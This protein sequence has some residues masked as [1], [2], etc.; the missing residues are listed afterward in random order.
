MFIDTQYVM[1]QYVLQED[2]EFAKFF[3]AV[4]NKFSL[5]AIK[6]KIDLDSF[7]KIFLNKQPKVNLKINEI[8]KR[9]RQYNINNQ[10]LEKIIN[11]H[12]KLNINIVRSNPKKFYFN[13]AISNC[14]ND[15]K[16]ELSISEQVFG[17]LI[18]FLAVL[19]INSFL[20]SF[21]VILFGGTEAAVQTA[22]F[23]TT[24][25]VAPIVEESGKLISVE[26][27][28]TGTYFI[29]FNIGE[30][31]LYIFNLLGKYSLPQIIMGRILATIM[32]AICTQIHIESHQ[33][34]T[35]GVGWGIAVL[36][37]ML[38]NLIASMSGG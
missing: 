20:L 24:V 6:E 10:K 11:K 29:V 37:H 8:K 3:A 14:V 21:F 32:H 34:K 23:I 19:V 33:N 1:D 28:M 15:I 25:F 38:W 13:T 2:I 5:D 9:L 30:W 27:K 26:E 36:I 12:V 7:K 16:Q 4:K 22:M 17:S 31:L 18:L 35:S